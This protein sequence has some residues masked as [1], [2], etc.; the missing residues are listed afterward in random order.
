MSLEK[1]SGGSSPRRWRQRSRSCPTFI[2]AMP[3]SLESGVEDF[4]PGA[5]DTP[6]RMLIPRNCTGERGDGGD[7]NDYSRA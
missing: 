6:D 5:Q 3:S 2:A 4:S 1:A 7:M